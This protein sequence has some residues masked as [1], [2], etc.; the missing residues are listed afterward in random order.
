MLTALLLLIPISHTG[1]AMT[2]E[3]GTAQSIS[4][5]LKLNTRSSTKAELVGLDDVSIMILWTK[6]FMEGQGYKIKNNIL[7]QD[8]KRTLL[9]LNN[10]K[11]KGTRAFNIQY[12]FLTDQ[13][14][15]NHLVA[16]YYP[17]TKMVADFMFKLLKE[18]SFQE[19]RKESKGC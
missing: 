2:Y 17:T 11:H 9:L 5:E 16:E 4:C 1:A 15:M 8:N 10:G 12:F 6:L 13:I 18:K 19:F 7:Y 3:S 14:E